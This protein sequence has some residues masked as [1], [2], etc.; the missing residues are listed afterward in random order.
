MI[1][2]MSALP[3]AAAALEGRVA[4][5]EA[6]DSF[7]VVNTPADLAGASADFV[8]VLQGDPVPPFPFQL[9]TA[10]EYETVH[11]GGGPN[12]PV[13]MRIHLNPDPPPLPSAHFDGTAIVGIVGL[14]VSTNHYISVFQVPGVVLDL[15]TEKVIFASL[16]L[17]EIET[18]YLYLFE[19]FDISGATYEKGW[20]LLFGEDA[21]EISTKTLPSIEAVMANSF[22]LPSE[23]SVNYVSLKPNPPR[24]AGL[25]CRV[26]GHYV[27]AGR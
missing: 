19:G 17:D 2:D 3:A 12:L 27:P 4:D 13:R 14:A 11:P 20:Y 8:W 1:K 18:Q 5:L 10:A 26:G 25:Y 16:N 21:F 7:V 15:P 24:P 23:V 6:A 22:A 9:Q